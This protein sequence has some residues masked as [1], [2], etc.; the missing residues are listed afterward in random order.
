MQTLQS[1][2]P[3]FI[4]VAPLSL[5]WWYSMHTWWPKY[6]LRSTCI[7]TRQWIQ[8]KTVL[9]KAPLFPELCI[10]LLRIN[11]DDSFE[12]ITDLWLK[13]RRCAY[14]A[15]A[16][17]NGLSLQNTL[18]P[19]HRICIIIKIAHACMRRVTPKEKQN[20][21]LIVPLLSFP[22]R[23]KVTFCH[24]SASQILLRYYKTLWIW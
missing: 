14:S 3:F 21:V 23:S 4:R 15:K 20:M 24:K 18:P 11:D 2:T 8:S 16:W 19:Y 9:F 5:I 6:S 13:G 22:L 7:D 1:M 12:C 17:C 10:L